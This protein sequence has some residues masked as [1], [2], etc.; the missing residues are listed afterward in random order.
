MNKFPAPMVLCIGGHDPSA[1]A[2]I[3]ADIK[4]TAALKSYALGVVSALTVQTHDTFYTCSWL[5]ATQIIEQLNPLLQQYRP[6]A[7]KIGVVENLDTLLSICT[8]I[9][10]TLGS[11]VPI[12]WDPILKSS[13]GGLFHKKW[14]A[15]T[16]MYIAKNINILCPNVKEAIIMDERLEPIIQYF[17]SLQMIDAP[18]QSLKEFSSSLETFFMDH[19]HFSLLITGIQSKSLIYDLYIN[20]HT[21]CP[22]EI[23]AQTCD[24]HGTGCV[25]S[26][27]IAC[28]LA[29]S[30]S[31]IESIR[32]AQLVVQSYRKSHPSL[33]GWVPRLGE[34]N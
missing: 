26:T 33:L 15:N 6:K 2:G 27:T 1:G 28:E 18:I 19:T 34:A 9:R 8:T 21:I 25:Y 30:Y 24:K 16:L 17:E 29:K 5:S 10:K 20:N 31:P 3:L 22:L 13:S 14:P 12:I 32:T 23:A 11:D 7:V 4:T